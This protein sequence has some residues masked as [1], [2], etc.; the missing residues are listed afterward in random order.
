MKQKISKILSEVLKKINPPEE[1]IEFIEEHSKKF[2]EH[3][4]KKIKEAGLKAEIF[5]G[6]SFAKKTVIKKDEYDVDIFLRFDKSYGNKIS[7][8][9]K[10]LLDGF[11]NV[12]VVHGSRDYFRINLGKG[13]TLE[14]IPVIKVKNPKESNNITDLSYS[15]VNYIKK[16]VKSQKILDGIK[17][18][19]AFCYANHCYGAE[20]Y[21]GG[22]SGYALELLVYYYGG[23]EKFLKAMLKPLK[24]KK[25]VKNMW[26]EGYEKDWKKMEKK[27]VIDIEKDY[28]NKNQIF[29]DLNSAKLQSPIIL[30]D[31]TYKQR[32]AAAAL[33][34]ETLDKFKKAAREFLENPSIESFE[35]KK[36]DLK[37]IKKETK[38]KKLEFILIEVKTNKQEGDVAGSKLLK[39]NRYLTG[40]IEKLFDIKNKGFNYNGKKSARFFFVV[41]KKKEILFE[42]PFVKD[43]ENAGRFKKK[44]KNY[45]IK[46]GK[47]F[48]KEIFKEN[49]S[50]FVKNWKAKEKNKLKEMYIQS[51]KILE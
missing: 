28:K 49:I 3:I 14:L 15:H 20:S 26:S 31:P 33:S 51:F 19:K 2:L 32:N 8:L 41:K 7:E 42:G 21:V 35:I 16:R 4:G 27:I 34:Q 44:H 17:L 6:G 29:M 24:I 43:S 30:I 46:K 18:A 48:S 25:S 38:K 1:D 22:F 37:K 13:N 40:E 47:L 9:T 23:F 36:T 12:T 10:K 39:F 50:E 45:T 5:V 11:K